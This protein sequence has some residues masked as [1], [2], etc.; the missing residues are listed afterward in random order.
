MHSWRKPVT[1]TGIFEILNYDLLP[2]T[3]LNCLWMSFCSPRKH[4]PENNSFRLYSTKLLLYKVLN[5]VLCVCA[6]GYVCVCVFE[7]WVFSGLMLCF[8]LRISNNNNK[9]IMGKNWVLVVSLLGSFFLRVR[10]LW[11]HWN[12]LCLSARYGIS[13]SILCFLLKMQ[14]CLRERGD[15]QP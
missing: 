15:I 13:N 12:I 7:F 2:W 11:I 8:S 1:S 10:K 6:C 14:K 3:Q 4:G 5:L 9:I